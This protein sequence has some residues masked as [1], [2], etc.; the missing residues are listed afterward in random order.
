M[1]DVITT[2]KPFLPDELHPKLT[3]SYESTLQQ[4][5]KVLDDRNVSDAKRIDADT[6]Q[7]TVN[8]SP[9]NDAF[10]ENLLSGNEEKS[11]NFQQTEKKVVDLDVDRSIQMNNDF[12]DD[13]SEENK[14]PALEA[15]SKNEYKSS[16]FDVKDF[17][18][19]NEDD[20]QIDKDDEGIPELSEETESVMKPKPEKFSTKQLDFLSDLMSIHDS[21]DDSKAAE[22][23]S[24]AVIDK[25]SSNSSRKKDLFDD[26]TDDEADL[27]S[28]FG[29][30]SSSRSNVKLKGS[31]NDSM[32]AVAP[33]ELANEDLF[34][35]KKISSK[36]R[37]SKESLFDDE[38]DDD[39]FGPATKVSHQ[40]KS[41]LRLRVA[42]FI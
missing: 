35:G 32:N 41:V 2:E 19:D 29:T 21:L 24:I 12:E 14:D 25:S 9:K 18:G 15:L 33:N 3:L 28:S 13:N 6:L 7:D 38:E 27:F 37:V 1:K 39:L 4:I 36:T 16:L 34:S 26:D 11:E 17:A 23:T 8:V 22:P 20:K 40:G 5:D 31:N 42:L 30:K 10:I